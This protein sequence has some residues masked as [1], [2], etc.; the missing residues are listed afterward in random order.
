MRSKYRIGLAMLGIFAGG[1]S[2]LSGSLSFSITQIFV[3]LLFVSCLY[4]YFKKKQPIT[5]NKYLLTLF[6]FVLFSSVIMNYTLF[7]YANLKMF[8]GLIIYVLAYYLFLILEKDN[9]QSVIKL[10]FNLTFIASLIAIIQELAFFLNIPVL[11][12][13]NYIGIASHVSQSDVFLRVNS[14]YGEP[15]HYASLMIPSIYLIFLS[16]FKKDKIFPWISKRKAI[17]IIIGFVLSFSLVGYVSLLIVLFYLQITNKTNIL[18]TIAVGFLIIIVIIGSFIYSENIQSKIM[19]VN[20]DRE[21]IT[22]TNNLS[23]F[24]MYSN[25]EVA[26]EAFN[27]SP[28]WGSGINT[29]RF[30]YEQ[31]MH[32][33]Y[34]DSYM[35]LNSTGDSSFYTHIPS[36][37]GVL[38]IIVFIFP[39]IKYRIKNKNTKLVYL[40]YLNEMSILFLLTN[41]LRSGAYLDPKIWFFFAIILITFN[42]NK[43]YQRNENNVDNFLYQEALKNG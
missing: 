34:S 43:S 2:T 16:I 19:S 41:G 6:S 26:L 31:F 5:I 40:K 4:S 8:I 30:S 29:H 15:A 36:E 17:I 14:L 11:Y 37:F 9:I 42:L 3:I 33:L 25:Y 39:I 12:D 27:K 18:K 22:S 38:G 1:F 20:T 35:E 23:F 21:T 28:F 10:F 13:T 7:D 24:A 32:Y